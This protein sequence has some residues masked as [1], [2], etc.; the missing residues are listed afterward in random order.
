MP[1]WLGAQIWWRLLTRDLM[2]IVLVVR[3][4]PRSTTRMFT[5]A[6]IWRYFSAVLSFN[7]SAAIREVWGSWYDTEKQCWGRQPCVNETLLLGRFV[8]F[9]A[10]QAMPVA[11]GRGRDRDVAQRQPEHLE[12]SLVQACCVRL[13][14]SVLRSAQCLLTK[15]ACRLQKRIGGL[16]SH[17]GWTACS[18]SKQ[19]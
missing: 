19:N 13:R 18:D 1:S 8:F 6:R 11:R 17:L 7:A 16:V 9:L 4:L 15:I 3:P 2:I 12:Q 14:K 10:I 5:L